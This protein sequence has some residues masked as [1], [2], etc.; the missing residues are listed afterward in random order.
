MHQF[1]IRRDL[2]PDDRFAILRQ[3]VTGS[4]EFSAL[5][6][7]GILTLIALMGHFNW[8]TGRCD[9]KRTTLAKDARI[10]ERSVS[11]ALAELEAADLILKEAH[12]VSQ[13]RQQYAILTPISR[14]IG[15]SPD[16]RTRDSAVRWE[17]TRGTDNRDKTSLIPEGRVADT[18][19]RI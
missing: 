10:S 17:Q 14:R 7:S 11:R 2:P 4:P 12:H 3:C 8:K 1:D 16:I 19:P 5:S 6:R 9:P 13:I 18:T 15:D